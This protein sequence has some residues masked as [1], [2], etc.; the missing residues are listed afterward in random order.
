MK[1]TLTLL[2]FP[3][4]LISLISCTEDKSE[5]D[6]K[7]VN[8][9]HKNL[10]SIK[11]LHNFRFV[12]NPSDDDFLSECSMLKQTPRTIQIFNYSSS[13]EKMLPERT[14][15]YNRKG[16]LV[17]STYIEETG[18]TSLTYFYYDKSGNRFLDIF[19]SGN[20]YDTIG[21]L[22]NFNTEKHITEELNYNLRRRELNNYTARS[23]EPIN[24]NSLNITE[25]DYESG[26]DFKGVLPFYKTEMVLTQIETNSIEVNSARTIYNETSRLTKSKENH[27]I[28]G[29]LIINKENNLSKLVNDEN[30]NWIEK[31]G[32]HFWVKRKITYYNN[33]DS[34]F[35]KEYKYSTNL[36][37]T[38]DSVMSVIVEKAWKNYNDKTN[39]YSERHKKYTKGDYGLNINVMETKNIKEFTPE[40]WL[41]I[42]CDSGQ[43]TGYQGKCY[44][45]GYNTPVL[46]KNGSNLRCLAIVEKIND[47]FIL[48]KESF[49]AIEG[50]IDSE[51]DLIF[52][53]YNE[54]NFSLRISQGK[55]VIGYNYMRGESSYTFG[56]RNKIGI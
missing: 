13:Q 43:L 11:N 14:F 23:F 46:D 4:F 55:I 47:S 33:S 44:V 50:F 56:F 24:D 16:E 38:L 31:K 21:R 1:A 8:S 5:N 25:T 30:K 35:Q 37:S 32:E 52:N 53:G 3:F 54:T 42:S 51:N 26:L 2:I 39:A 7:N 17:K 10:L 20:K 48:R 36:I 9:T 19:I 29:N 6:I 41:L 15:F 40:M 45:L 27:L 49:S 28:Q 12:E 34:E 18:D 22:R